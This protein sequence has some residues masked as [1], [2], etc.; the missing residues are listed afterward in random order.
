MA[1]PA[2]ATVDVSALIDRRITPF[3]LG[4]FVTCFLIA[5]IDGTDS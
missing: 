5:L 4:V 2:A 1:R 3:Q